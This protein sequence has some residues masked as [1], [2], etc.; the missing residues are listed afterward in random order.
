MADSTSRVCGNCREAVAISGDPQRVACTT[1][2]EY[3]PT[4][5]SG[6]C[7]YYAPKSSRA[8]VSRAEMER[9]LLRGLISQACNP[10]AGA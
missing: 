2:L 7:Q 10:V 9:G 8:E 5:H 1:W 6:M 4:D 3:K